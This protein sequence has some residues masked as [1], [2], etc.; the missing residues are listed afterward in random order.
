MA[1]EV[2]STVLW[3]AEVIPSS[4]SSAIMAA[5]PAPAPRN[6]EA[7]GSCG[8]QFVIRGEQA[9]DEPCLFLSIPYQGEKQQ[10][11]WLWDSHLFL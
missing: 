7:A 3:D 6:A 8:L 4:L 11:Q 9:K 1:L 5:I 10:S 2:T